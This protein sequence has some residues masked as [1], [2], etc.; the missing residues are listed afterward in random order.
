VGYVIA[1]SPS[2]FDE[3]RVY[4]DFLRGDF[5]SAKGLELQERDYEILRLVQRKENSPP[6]ALSLA[7]GRASVATDVRYTVRCCLLTQCTKQLN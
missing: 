7:G 5:L 6:Q 2:F 1:S 3:G 4:D